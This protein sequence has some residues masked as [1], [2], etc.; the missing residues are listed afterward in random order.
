MT[1]ASLI[2]ALLRLEDPAGQRCLLEAHRTALDDRLL[3][4]MK[5]LANHL[6]WA[7]V[8]ACLRM[9][10]AMHQSATVSQVPSHRALALLAEANIEHKLGQYQAAIAHYDEA[11]AL[12]KQQGHVVDQA[13]A[14]IG[15]LSSLRNLGRYDEALEVGRWAAQVL[16]QHGKWLRLGHLL[17]N[18]GTIYGRLGDDQ[19][20][21]KL[22]DRA[23]ELY[24]L[25]GSAG[26]ES[27]ASVEINRSIVLRN[28]GDYTSSI[29][30][31]QSAINLFHRLGQRIEEARAIQSLATTHFVLGRYN[32][33]LE[34][35]DQVRDV[36]LAEGLRR[37]AVLVDLF[38]SDCLLQLGRLADVLDKATEIRRTFAELGT[39]FEVGQALLN[40]A[41]AHTRLGRVD[42][43][44]RA[45]AEAR[46]LFEAEGISVWVAAVDLEMADLL[47]KQG[48][49]AESLACA[50]Q[51]AATF[52][53]RL[54]ARHVHAQ[55]MIARTLLA[56][57]RVEEARALATEALRESEAREL[58]WLT[59]QIDHLLGLASLATG[60][61][62]GARHAFQQ[63]LETLERLRG[64]V[65]VEF[66]ADFLAGKQ[67]PYEDL[68][69]LYLDEDEPLPALETVERAKSRAL[70][71]LL[72][73]RLDVS[74]R[75]RD[76]GDEPVIEEIRRLRQARDRLYRRWQGREDPHAS[77]L[78]QPD[79]ASEQLQREM[80][81]L[82]KQITSLV[83][84]L[85][86]R[87][88]G[89]AHDATLWRVHVEPVQ[90]Y[91]DA[92]SV[93]VE[94]FVAGDEV[95]AFT[96]TPDRVLAHR[97]LG[98]HKQIGRLMHLL[99]LNLSSVAHNLAQPALVENLAA[100][101]RTLLQQLYN[102]IIRPLVSD[103]TAYPRLLIVPH[104]PLHYL[105]FHALYDGS[106]Y[107]IDRH[108]VAY[109]PAAS[110]LRYCVARGHGDT[111]TGRHGDGE[112]F[113]VSP[114]QPLILAHS[115]GG[116]LPYILEEAKVVREKIGGRAYVEDE[117]VLAR[118]GREAGQARVLHIAAHGDF[119][120]DNPLFS[121]LALAD[122]VLTTLDVFNLQLNA[123]LV[124]LSACQTGRNVVGGGD[125]LIGLARG[126]L[127]AGAASLLL[128]LW[129]VE[130]RST[131]RLME[132]FYD[133]LRAGCSKA[134]ALRLAQKNLMDYA[135]PTGCQPYAH[136]YFWAPFVLV[137][138]RGAL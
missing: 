21:L 67:G 125:E 85:L 16:E 11:A 5:A 24:E 66:R 98:T 45:F 102:V 6:M 70:V 78:S 30:A 63:S 62:T 56:M 71:D 84:R 122:G 130:D 49:Y 64:Q 39:R 36:F 58:P 100:N 131:V 112:S 61:R 137:G 101:A 88:A 107:L 114:G 2:D 94:Y 72:A 34:L 135:D 96:V 65:M 25:S 87:N 77:D 117:A 18:M 105:P 126:F 37:D 43:A 132:A 93:L 111:E 1:N 38:I 23:R 120:P 103:L 26:T 116:K 29:Q 128:T 109:L 115:A 9:V 31:S 15:K 55:W 57:Q 51:A 134:G 76:P 89:Y 79:G 83:H 8:Q 53:G 90:P 48:R 104:G 119:R 41:I 69:Q 108:E 129:R 82:E 17:D 12:Y 123:S 81:A 121:G 75:A 59:Y 127:Y 99:W 33:A 118:L 73:Y 20:A 74:L 27:I 91:L 136:P 97:R 60:D 113:S 44:L 22:F 124:T 4:E 133:H 95:L 138:D 10:Q 35:F 80:L 40:E 110:V 42:E 68:I 54:P 46:R 13:V 106:S 7:D 32:T 3:A 19:Q 86:I 47:F 28:L 52:A 14:Y 92:E 50:S